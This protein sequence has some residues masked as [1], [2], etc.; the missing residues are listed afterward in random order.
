MSSTPMSEELQK[1]IKEK[2][3]QIA[4]TASDMP[5]VVIIHNIPTRSVEYMSPKGEEVLGMPLE[6]I[7]QLGP[8]YFDRFFNPEDVKDYIPKVIAL[9][10]RNIIDESTSFFQ[11]VRTVEQQDWVWHISSVKILMQDDQ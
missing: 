2:I 5:G 11:Q 7:K 4:A 3:E 8:A 9:L 1:K 6:E 10:E